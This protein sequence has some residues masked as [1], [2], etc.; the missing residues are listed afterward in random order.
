MKTAYL[1]AAEL[2]MFRMYLTLMY[3]SESAHP[4]YV[5]P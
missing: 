2:V 1:L 4:T 5:L 3:F